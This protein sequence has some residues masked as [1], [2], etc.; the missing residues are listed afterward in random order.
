MKKTLDIS[1]LTKIVDKYVSLHLF[2]DSILCDFKTDDDLYDN[3][4][5]AVWLG[6]DINTIYEWYDCVNVKAIKY[7]GD[8][9]FV[10]LVNKYTV[11]DFDDIKVAV[12]G[13]VEDIVTMSETA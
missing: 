9:K 8:G 10:T 1:L 2:G 13:I 4:M 12:E 6:L 7:D 11:D 5:K 3:L